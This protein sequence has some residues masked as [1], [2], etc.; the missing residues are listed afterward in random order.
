MRRSLSL[1]LVAAMLLS[2]VIFTIPS[3]SAA[4]EKPK[5]DWGNAYATAYRFGGEVY[6]YEVTGAGSYADA[7]PSSDGELVNDEISPSTDDVIKLD[8]AIDEG[9][10]GKPALSISSEYASQFSGKNGQ[11]NVNI[12][13]PSKE[14][15]YFQTNFKH[16]QLK[17][18][19]FD[20]LQF[21]AYFLWDDD[22]FYMAVDVLDLDGHI[23]SKDSS[24]TEGA[25]NGDAVQFRLDPD[26]PNSIKDGEG[27]DGKLN[28]FP[29]KRMK[30]N[31][32]DTYSEFPNFIISLTQDI[33][34]QKVFVERWDAAKRYNVVEVPPAK[35]GDEVTYTGSESDVSQGVGEY[36]WGPVYA[37]V[38]TVEDPDY[39]AEL[40]FRTRT[41]YEIAIPWEYMDSAKEIIESGEYFEPEV[42]M[43]LGMSLALM[44]GQFSVGGDY[45]SDLEWGNGVTRDA[46]YHHY[47]VA[48]GSN[49]LVLDGTDF[50]DADI[51][52]HE[53]FK[54]PTC[55]NGYKCTN[56]GYEKGHSLG[57]VYEY[58][59]AALPTADTVGGMTGTCTRPG[60]GY[61]VK[62]FIPKT[63]YEKIGSFT[64]DQTNLK[65]LP[66]YFD[67]SDTEEGETGWNK[68]WAYAD[69]SLY[70]D[71]NGK[72]R[73]SYE[74]WN[75]Q[76][77]SNLTQLNFTGT[78]FWEDEADDML[79][80]SYSMD[81]NLQGYSFP[82]ADDPQDANTNNMVGESGYTS[83]IYMCYGGNE[84]NGYYG[85]L[86]YIPDEDQY[87]F[88]IFRGNRTESTKVHSTEQMEKW[89]IAYNKVDKATAEELISFNEWHTLK[90]VY[91]DITQSS[92][93]FWDGELMVSA[94]TELR[95]HV[96]NDNKNAPVMRTFD[97]QF[98][99][100]NIEV[101]RLRSEDPIPDW[102]NK[103]EEPGPGGDYT[104]TINGQESN[105]SAGDQVTIKAD[106]FYVKDKLGYRFATWSGDVDALADATQN[107]TTFTMPAKNV[108]ITAEYILI[109]DTNGD[110]VLA[111]ADALL[112]ARM[113]AGNMPMASAGDING[114]GDVTSA[115]VILMK[116]YL[117]DSYIPTK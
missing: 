23:N 91:D 34:T 62:K 44:N 104:V 73:G 107:E 19:T 116:R 90:V 86:C 21:D 11:K 82:K 36:G 101:E 115:D 98:Y 97:V 15:T 68:L 61:I 63:Q 59:E 113:A 28:P 12:D 76:A 51:C 54:A 57:H 10:W 27:Y 83:G 3:A 70:K 100:K 47:E 30:Y 46:S 29:W 43:Q 84:K 6:Y 38:T 37:S 92:F 71:E 108:T 42:G 106:A 85:G 9:E 50:R 109:G 93:V 41:Q 74:V 2:M 64:E 17:N 72:T 53:T 105:Y 35:P 16:A 88:A 58:S 94:F 4:T 79:S 75:G 65:A 33:K 48:G 117:V 8:G 66:D 110:G 14:N 31:W 52:T 32:Q 1:V 25:W 60:C 67:V 13:S 95:K 56:C 114:D 39:D 99:A 89:A 96:R 7:K 80:W 111:P 112:V 102:N 49:C 81:V 55:E 77:V 103:P 40:W 78:A 5:L 24:K 26:G 20:P 87:Y 18:L 69:G 22:Y 45:D